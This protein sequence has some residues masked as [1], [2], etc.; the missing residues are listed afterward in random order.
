MVCSVPGKC[1]T[2]DHDPLYLALPKGQRLAAN[3]LSAHPEVKAKWAAIQTD[4]VEI[5]RLV[6]VANATRED[7]VVV[8]KH[9]H[10][11]HQSS[12]AFLADLRTQVCAIF[13]LPLP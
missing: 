3:K 1:R 4:E 9:W 6:A 7:K 13:V 8:K 10:S 2:A 5:A 11:R 12:L